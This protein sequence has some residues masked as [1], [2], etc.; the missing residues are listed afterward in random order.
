MIRNEHFRIV[1]DGLFRNIKPFDEDI[2]IDFKPSL[3]SSIVVSS[4]LIPTGF[5]T[6]MEK[7]KLSKRDI[8]IN[9]NDL[10]PRSFHYPLDE[11]IRL[12][13]DK[14]RFEYRCMFDKKK[15][16]YPTFKPTL[17]NFKKIYGLFE[18]CSF[19]TSFLEAFKEKMEEKFEID[20]AK[21]W[22][23]IYS[24]DPKLIPYKTKSWFNEFPPFTHQKIML[25]Y[26]LKLP[27][28]A[29]L[30]EMGTGKTYPTIV[31]II[32]KIKSNKI[33]K[34]FIIV[35]KT[36]SRSVWESQ[37]KKYSDL[38]VSVI[39]SNS[40]KKRMEEINF[41]ADVYIIG[42][43]LFA[44]M[45]ET[46]IPMIDNRTMVILD[47][48]SKIKNPSAKRSKAIHRLGRHVK[49]KIILNGTPI[50]QGAQDIFSQFLFLDC[51]ESFGTSYERFLYK[52]F[53]KE[54]YQWKWTIKGKD[55][56]NAISDKI[57]NVGI[58]Y[59]K[60][61]CL[62]LPPKLYETREI[63]MTNEQWKSYEEM[64]DQ[65]VTWIETK[66]QRKERIDASVVV[67]KLLRLS[68]ITSGFSKNETGDIVRF[69]NN[70]K[71]NELSSM[72]DDMVYNGN[73][74]VIWARFV[75]DLEAI[76]KLCDDKKIKSGLLYGKVNATNREKLVKDF[77]EKKVS[78]FIGQQGAGGLGID[79]YTSNIV[80]YYSNDYTLLNR[81]QSEDRTHRKGSEKHNK[82]TYY[83]LVANG[84]S[85]Q[86]TIDHHILNVVLK[87]KKN[88]ADLITK[89]GIRKILGLNALSVK[90]A[91]IN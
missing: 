45:E 52:Y 86:G 81:L 67:T 5:F 16:Y 66:E 77:L 74:V 56:M 61:E 79:L 89:D 18:N 35:P 13:N 69:K 58:R 71:L 15:I 2:I 53:Y 4:P 78:V 38:I 43:E 87:E 51:G 90:G 70:P 84:P 21:K 7:E 42:Y 26:G 19:T 91:S 64:R 11:R 80:I 68:Q 20:N 63:N 55:E 57:Y 10:I 48:S 29:N 25:E 50:T 54:S 6:E 88:I 46:I 1:H 22:I 40:I 65:L 85:G 27:Y 72:L 44:V 47:E 82:V 76:K 49:H 32:E 59:L 31:T 8:N 60:D 37:I 17:E 30:S 9:K 36:I 34:A 28:F 3:I 75:P 39:D 83:D 12:L 62:D 73:Q 33:D 41:D 24:N 14:P 23:D